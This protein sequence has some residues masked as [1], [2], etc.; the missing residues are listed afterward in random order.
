MER[1]S[2]PE[3]AGTAGWA[4]L[5]SGGAAFALALACLLLMGQASPVPAMRTSVWAAVVPAVVGVLLAM[6]LPPRA[7]ALAV[8][9]GA[10]Q[11]KVLLV[12]AVAYPLALW[13]AG[14]AG[15]DGA[16]VGV[17]WALG[18]PLL[19][20]LLPWLVLRVLTPGGP[21]LLGGVAGEALWR[22]AG[23]WRWWA[24]VPAVVAFTYLG[25][26]SPLAPPLPTAAGMDLNELLPLAALTFV[27]ANVVEELFF[28]VAL[29][30]RLE[31]SLGRWP[32]I[33]ISS[34]LFALLHLPIDA[35][36][37]AAPAGLPLGLPALVVFHGTFGLLA[38]H[39]WSRYRNVWVLITLH[40]VVN[41]LPLLLVTH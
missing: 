24:P 16:T 5:L 7:P 31:A 26:F 37:A 20:L 17:A 3:V 11:L 38:G 39:L 34:L 28:R 8:R 36:T 40:S 22:P 41:T 30:T 23:S 13:V 6:T 18:K 35:Q 1:T 29:Q 12:I 2:P 33:V 15:I 9:S 32:G 10:P 21:P 25:L 19:L 14:L 4:A 27:T